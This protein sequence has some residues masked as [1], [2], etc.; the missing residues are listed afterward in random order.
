MLSGYNLVSLEVNGTLASWSN[1]MESFKDFGRSAQRRHERSERGRRRSPDES[2]GAEADFL[3]S[4][5]DSRTEVTVVLESGERLTGRVRYY[6][7]E[8]LSI[9]LADRGLNVL[10]KKSSVL[11]I[12][13]E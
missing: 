5:V 3:R 8:V 11:S 2:T 10:L 7:C 4:L 13:E 1:F 9:K 12:S 6:D